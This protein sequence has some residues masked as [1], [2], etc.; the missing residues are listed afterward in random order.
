[1]GSL[2]TTFGN[3]FAAGATAIS[4]RGLGANATLV[5][6]NGRR[7]ALYPRADDFQKM[8]SDLSSIPVER[9]SAS[10]S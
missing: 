7:L 9:S 1:M 5:L 10:R 8:F 3:G 4:L 6:L 2:P